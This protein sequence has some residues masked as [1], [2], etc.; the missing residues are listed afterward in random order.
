MRLVKGEPDQ[1]GEIFVR[2]NGEV[3]IV[4]ARFDICFLSVVA[5]EERLF[6]NENLPSRGAGAFGICHLAYFHNDANCIH[7]GVLGEPMWM[8]STT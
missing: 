2:L 5:E 1:A 6:E 7:I 4:F 8:K 3:C